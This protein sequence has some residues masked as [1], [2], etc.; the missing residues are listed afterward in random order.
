[1]EKVYISFDSKGNVL[2]VSQNLEQLHKYSQQYLAD[3]RSAG[4]EDSY[5]IKEE[6]LLS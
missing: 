1:M 2:F 4:Y 3:I 6:I 5:T